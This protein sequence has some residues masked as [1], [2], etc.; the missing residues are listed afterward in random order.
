MDVEIQRGICQELRRRQPQR[1]AKRHLDEAVLTIEAHHYLWRTVDQN[2]HVLD[3]LIQSRRNRQAEKRF[4]HKRNLSINF[5]HL[6]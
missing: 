4:F 1:G 2:S 5:K 3:I 6:G